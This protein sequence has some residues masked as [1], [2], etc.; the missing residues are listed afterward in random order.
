MGSDWMSNLLILQDRDMK[1]RQI[2]SQLENLPKERAS[3]LAKVKELEE[4]IVQLHESV[5]T[6]EVK[7]K[8]LESEMAGIE[9]QIVKYKNQQ[10]QVKKNEEYQALTHEIELGEGKISDLESKEIELLY[11]LD[12]ARKVRDEQEVEVSERIQIE[13]VV[14][15]RLDE[16]EVN[17]NNEIGDAEAN[18]EKAQGVLDKRMLSTYRRTAMGMKFPIIVPV[19]QQMCNG[20]HMRVSSGVDSDAKAGIEITTCDNCNRILYS[21]S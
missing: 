16:K 21:D 17:L 9:A 8:A 5:K 11:E 7:S 12:E 1:L 3:G 14:L 4:E 19:R 13:K 20:C 18:F 15:T 10:L 2:R 6:L